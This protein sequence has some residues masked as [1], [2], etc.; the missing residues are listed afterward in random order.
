LGGAK[1]VGMIKGMAHAWFSCFVVVFNLYSFWV[2]YKVIDENTAMIREI[3]AKIAA[4][5]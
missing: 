2:E 1:D 3:D 4:K 5:T